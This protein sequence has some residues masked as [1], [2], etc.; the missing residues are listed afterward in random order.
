MSVFHTSL[1]REKIIFIEDTGNFDDLKEP[2]IIRSNRLAMRLKRKSEHEDIVI[3]CQNM[4]DT[5][6][7]AGQIFKN[8]YAGGGAFLNR[9]KPFDWEKLWNKTISDYEKKYNPENWLSVY[10]DG[11]CIFKTHSS[12]FADII[13]Q[14]VLVTKEDYDGA[15]DV[16]EYALREVGRSIRIKHYTNVAAVFTD[17]IDTLRCGIIR[18]SSEHDTMFNFSV[19]GGGARTKRII[20]SFEIAAAFLD[21]I[22]LRFIIDMAQEKLMNGSISRSSSQAKQ[23]HD[24]YIRQGELSRTI[25]IFED[26][27]HVRYRPEKPD[28]FSEH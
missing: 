18:R 1:I 20:Q 23:M 6:R 28:F 25:N 17:N 7:V 15:M 19:V 24:S 14:C 26:V 2:T 16:A 5:L 9:E 11:K 22:N 21:A 13:E 3:R 12:P 8:F 27:Y 10:I 4:P